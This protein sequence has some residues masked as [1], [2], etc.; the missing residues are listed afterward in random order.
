[1]GKLFPGHHS[2]VR[3]NTLLQPDTCLGSALFDHRLRGGKSDKLFNDLTRL[4][5][6]DQNIYV[7]HDL[8]VPPETAGHFNTGTGNIFL[9][10][11]FEQRRLLPGLVYQ[12]MTLKFLYVPNSVDYL[13][14]GLRAKAFKLNQTVFNT[15]VFKLPDTADTQFFVKYPGLLGPE[16]GYFEHF[17]EPFGNTFL[18]FTVK[19]QVTCP[20]HF[21][22]L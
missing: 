1:M 3:G 13:F 19:P 7:S 18:E 2:Q 8:P 6:S 4:L 9:K 12:E 21:L 14:L 16:S 17:N 20:D 11:P 10:P 5:G 15:G 22:D